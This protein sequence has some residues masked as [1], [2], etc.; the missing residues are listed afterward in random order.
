MKNRT[1]LP[2]PSDARRRGSPV[3][4]RYSRAH[5]LTERDWDHVISWMMSK[6]APC[7][8]LDGDEAEY[9]TRKS[10][11][12]ARFDYWEVGGNAPK[13]LFVLHPAMVG[14]A[15]IV[16]TRVR[17]GWLREVEYPVEEDGSGGMDK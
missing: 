8:G 6:G 16:L 15:P 2:N 14:G 9:F 10:T 7:E 5:P 11:Y 17:G 3:P 13:D 4:D 1:F 12:A